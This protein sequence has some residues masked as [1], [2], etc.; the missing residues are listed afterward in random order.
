M[1]NFQN[2]LKK[3][4][5]TDDDSTRIFWIIEDLNSYLHQNSQ[6]EWLTTQFIADVKALFRGWIVKHWGDLHESQNSVMKSMNKI[7]VKQ[8]FAFYSKAWSQR[9]EG[10]HDSENYRKFS[11]EWHT[12]LK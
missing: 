12:K 9:N 11:I 3:V 5:K 1:K 6:T 4:C 2:K 10:F 7:V 8:C